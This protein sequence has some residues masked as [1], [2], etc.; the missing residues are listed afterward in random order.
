MF[1]VLIFPGNIAQ[2]VERTDAFGLDS[3]QARAATVSHTAS[4]AGSAAGSR[5]LL[6]RLGIGQVDL[7]DPRAQTEEQ[8]DLDLAVAA[9]ADIEVG[10]DRRVI[11]APPKYFSCADRLTGDQRAIDVR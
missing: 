4:L 5:A 1:F 2:Y 10:V 6:R 7:T 9:I 11:A 3:D 8:G